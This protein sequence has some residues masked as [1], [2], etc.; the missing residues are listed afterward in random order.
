MYA[1]LH[2]YSLVCTPKDPQFHAPQLTSSVG[3]GCSIHKL[4]LSGLL[5]Y[6]VRLLQRVDG[7]VYA[8]GITNLNGR[9]ECGLG[10]DRLKLVPTLLVCLWTTCSRFNVTMGGHGSGR[11]SGHCLDAY[12]WAIANLPS[13]VKAIAASTPEPMLLG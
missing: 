11:V 10:L 4:F 1:R 12:T 9:R 8:Y 7:A 5:H 6:T 3:A 2:A 13:Q